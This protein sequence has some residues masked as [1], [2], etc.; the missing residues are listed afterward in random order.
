MHSIWQAHKV[1]WKVLVV[2]ILEVGLM[3]SI[4]YQLLPE[5]IMTYVPAGSADYFATPIAKFVWI[6]L[7]LF[8]LFILNRNRSVD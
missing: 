3:F 6:L 5:Q 8:V 2:S 7:P 1:I 4:V